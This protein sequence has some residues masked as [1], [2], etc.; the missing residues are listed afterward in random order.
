MGTQSATVKTYISSIKAVLQNDG[1]HWDCEQ[2]KLLSL[3]QACKFT[4]DRVRT[5]LPIGKPLLELLLFELERL[6]QQNYLI[7]LYR[8]LFMI[9]YYGLMRIGELT[10]GGHP[11][12]A[13]NMHAADDKEKIMLV[14]FSSKTH[15]VHSRPQTIRIWADS[16]EHVRLQSS[17]SPFKVTREYARA[18]GGYVQDDEQF[19]IFLTGRLCS[20]NM[21]GGRSKGS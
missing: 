3:T 21:C 10:Q 7:L 19:F 18:R 1:Y 2:F 17:F 5:R 4:N 15:G 6:Y 11:V 14:L 20:Q 16:A 13:K 12:K 8:C 9:A